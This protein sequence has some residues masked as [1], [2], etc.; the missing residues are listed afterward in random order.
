[1][2]I[3]A[4]ALECQICQRVVNGSTVAYLK[5]VL[6]SNSNPAL[7]TWACLD[8]LHVNGEEVDSS[9]SIPSKPIGVV[10]DETFD[11][12]GWKTNANL[13]ASYNVSQGALIQACVSTHRPRTQMAF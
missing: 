8:Y 3:S 7:L 4:P 6:K 12:A 1:M 10:L 5:V 9:Y 2:L 13:V 11:N